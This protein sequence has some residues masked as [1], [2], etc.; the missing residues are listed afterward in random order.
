MK[1]DRTGFLRLALA[2]IGAIL[3]S[4][5]TGLNPAPKT[6]LVAG[7]SG[8]TGQLIVQHLQRSGYQVRALVRDTAKARA[9]L[10]EDVEYVQADVKDPATLVAAVAGV[11]AVISSI[12]SR[13]KDG[14]DRPEMID[15]HGVRNLV[16][17]ARTARVGQFVLISS[18]GVT[19]DD[20]PLN[21]MFGDV[22]RWKLKG[23]DYLRQS[24]LAYTVVR[25]GGLLN[26]P[27]GRAD[28]AF[29]QGDRRFA[30]TVLSIP[31]EDVAIVCVEALRHPEA[32]FRTFEIHRTEGAPVTDWQARFAGLKPDAG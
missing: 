23:E 19:Q 5:C 9:Q 22:L 14:P 13:G 11:S 17:A 4:A 24:G 8:Q 18:R 1:I 21:R 29:E 15:Y 7:A 31:R 30:G 2:A 28:I 12:G 26:E 25:P 3:V 16:D 27:G 20:H 32:Q 6:I 10:G